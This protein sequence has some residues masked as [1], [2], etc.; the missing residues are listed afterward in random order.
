MSCLT[1]IIMLSSPVFLRG[2]RGSEG[3][4]REENGRTIIK[5]V[6][7]LSSKEKLNSLKGS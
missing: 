4:L 2:G 1:S 5:F 3:G 6:L 7:M